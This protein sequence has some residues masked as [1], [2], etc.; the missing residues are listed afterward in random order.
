[1]PEIDAIPAI[2]PKTT[3][4]KPICG[5]P[6]NLPDRSHPRNPTRHARASP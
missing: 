3:P 1:M 5:P 2:H 4:Q 6:S